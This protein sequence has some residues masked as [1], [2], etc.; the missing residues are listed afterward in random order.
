M[1]KDPCYPPHDPLH[2]KDDDL[3]P[4]R[5]IQIRKIKA[6][7]DSRHRS[8]KWTFIGVMLTIC[9]GFLYREYEL[10][11][12]AEKHEV[13]CLKK[14]DIASEFSQMQHLIAKDYMS[15]NQ[16]AARTEKYCRQIWANGK[17]SNEILK[18]QE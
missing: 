13:T 11:R 17:V 9:A 7:K 10:Y 18:N 14:E 12:I 8:T 5:I 1:F 16:R 15:L 2:I 3:T 4:D 6:E